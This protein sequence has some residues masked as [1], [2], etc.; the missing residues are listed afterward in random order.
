MLP[1]ISA[2]NDARLNWMPTHFTRA[3]SGGTGFA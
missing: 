3:G 1:E 2:R